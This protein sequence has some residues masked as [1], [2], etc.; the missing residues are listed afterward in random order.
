MK[1]KSEEDLLQS[2]ARER[3]GPEIVAGIGD[4]CAVIRTADRLQWRLFK[5][6]AVVE[7]RHYRRGTPAQAIGWKA[8][9][10]PLSDFAAMSGEPQ[11]ALVTVA[12]RRTLDLKWWR[13]LYRGLR[14]AG[15]KFKVTIIG[16]ETVTTAGPVVV[17]IAVSGVVEKA[18]CVFRRGGRKGDDLYVTGKLGG[19]GK[20]R[21]LRFVPRIE[22]SRWLTKKFRVHAMMDLSDGLAK[23][24]PRLAAASR[25]GFDLALDSVPRARECSLERALNEGEDYELL[26]ALSPRDRVKLAQEW[27]KRWRLP[28]TRIGQLTAAGFSPSLAGG[29]DHF[30]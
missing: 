6:D 22:Q 24:L 13:D 2:L 26:F 1:I 19:T 9:M 21:H 8:M 14:G 5:T 23:D 10:R 15:R 30:A 20:G 12:M 29:Y 16:G 18:R 27:R 4:D 17:V 3:T 28:L 25:C 7:G 11:H